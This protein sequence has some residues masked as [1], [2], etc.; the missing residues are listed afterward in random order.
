[1]KTGSEYF[2]QF[3][4]YSVMGWIYETIFC[5][6][7]NKKW[8]NRGFLY[9]PLCP[10]YGAG[11][12]ILAVIMRFINMELSWWQI[13][14]VG[15]AGS[16]ILEYVTHWGLEKL[17]HAKWWDYSNMPLN[18]KGRVCVP[19]SIGFGLASILIA[20]VIFPFV[21]F[22]TGWIPPLLM[23][24]VALVLMAVLSGDAAL[25]VSALTGFERELRAMD[26]VFNQRMEEL[27]QSVVERQKESTDEN[28]EERRL[29][30]EKLINRMG[31][32]GISALKRV[33]SFTPKAAVENVS[34]NFNARKNRVL[35]LIK[36]HRK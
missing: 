32:V 3:I 28:E 34:K 20:Y 35:T 29:H 7:K 30:V 8:E 17:F 27:V 2:V 12:T 15:Y 25:T 10:I 16:V 21:S 23:E 19:A 33:S 11:A 5:T 26:N 4:I 18:I 36:N 14:L 31:S 6:I 13:F 22:L 24:T 1:M 9:G